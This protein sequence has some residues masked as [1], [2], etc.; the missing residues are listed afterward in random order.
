MKTSTVCLLTM[1]STS[2]SCAAAEAPA[3]L[4]V[5]S[6]VSVANPNGQYALSIGR[7]NAAQAEAGPEG[8]FTA[9]DAVAKAR[10]QVERELALL[11]APGSSAA[12]SSLIVPRKES[13]P[14]ALAE[15][16]EDMAV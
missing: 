6:T 8:L 10:T 1:I 4:A 14:K 5:S 13:D 2:L 11:G 3:A 12:G 16:E 15:T 9:S 7:P